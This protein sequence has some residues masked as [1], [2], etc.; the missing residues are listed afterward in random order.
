MLRPVFKVRIGTV[1]MRTGHLF[2]FRYKSFNY[3]PEP[4]VI[5]LYA[6][7]GTHPT[8]GRRHN[9]FQAINL[10]YVPRSQRR[11]FCDVWV[12]LLEQYGG[13]IIFTW[14]MV[15]RQYPYLQLALRRYSLERGEIMALK[16]IP[17][18]EIK[19]AVVKSWAK[20][21]SKQAMLATVAKYK[22][23]A[24]QLDAKTLRRVFGGPI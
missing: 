3:D 11:Q 9:Y 10:N 5:A 23:A 21:F 4:T 22:A 2:Y 15:K 24:K 18:E 20:D 7:A 13:N 19:N 6:I 16:E 17:L 1:W 8:S 14:E 12:K